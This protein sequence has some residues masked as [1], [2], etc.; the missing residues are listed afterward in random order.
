MCL[1]R[2]LEEVCTHTT[3]KVY[4]AHLSTQGVLAHHWCAKDLVYL[5]HHC[6]YSADRVECLLDMAEPLT[7]SNGV[8]IDDEMRFFKG[9]SP[10]QQFE[11]GT[12]QGG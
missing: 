7:A 3:P 1:A 12:Q 6:F 5:A 4:I 8:S 11:R 10:A 2:F 9:N